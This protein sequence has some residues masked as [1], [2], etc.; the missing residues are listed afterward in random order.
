MPDSWGRSSSRPAADYGPDGE[1]WLAWPTDGRLYQHSH[2]PLVGNVYA[3]RLLLDDPAQAPVLEP[4]QSSKP[5]EVKPG[6]LNEPQDLKA[7][8]SYPPL[9]TAWRSGL[10]VE[11]STAT[12]SFP[13]TPVVAGTDLSSTF[14]A[15]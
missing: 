14:I 6:H 13:G 7:I 8:R 1:L 11:I 4:W 9:C 15:T 12:P 3:A 5:D 10:C 2:R